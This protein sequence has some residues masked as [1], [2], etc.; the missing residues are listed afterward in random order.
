MTP[1]PP[2]PPVQFLSLTQNDRPITNELSSHPARRRWCLFVTEANRGNGGD[3]RAL[4][5]FP[6]LPPV[7]FLSRTQ[8]DRPI[9]KE[10]SSHPARRRWCFFV[11]EANRGNGGDNRAITPFP[12][13]PPVQFLSLTQNDRPITKE[14]SSHPARRRWCLFVTEA[15]RGN[16]G[17]DRALT[18]FPPLPP[19]QFLSRT[20]NDRPITNELSSDPSNRRWNLFKQKQAEKTEATTERLLSFLRYLLFNFFPEH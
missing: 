13:L 2:L 17:D 16:G 20:Q 6:P 7:Q 15:N 9:T 11:T 1:F 3:N 19:V 8:N 10:L 14:L 5:P 18:P 12:P 4:T